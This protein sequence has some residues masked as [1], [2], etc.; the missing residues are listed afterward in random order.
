MLPRRK[1]LYNLSNIDNMLCFNR[2]IELR[3]CPRPILMWLTNCLTI[4]IYRYA[5]S[6]S[7]LLT[8]HKLFLVYYIGTFPKKKK[9]KK[10]NVYI[11]YSALVNF[12]Y[13]LC[14]S[15]FVARWEF[16]PKR[17]LN[18]GL[19][20]CNVCCYMKYGPNRAF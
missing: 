16:N 7:E 8:F 4:N 14:A 15:N 9:K 12:L 20:Q 11:I 1:I 6:S 2:N 18:P 17:F 19:F 10:Q 5:I 13:F 3:S